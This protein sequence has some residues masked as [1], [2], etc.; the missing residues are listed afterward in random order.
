MIYDVGQNV[1]AGEYE[2]R[3]HDV[4]VSHLLSVT[5]VD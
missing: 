4:H 5:R 1:S 2:N 3:K